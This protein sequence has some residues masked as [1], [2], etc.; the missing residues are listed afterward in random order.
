MTPGIRLATAAAAIF[1]IT[2]ASRAPADEYRFSYQLTDSPHV[3][4]GV[5]VGTLESDMNTFDIDALRD[6]DL[7]NVPVVDSFMVVSTDSDFANT[8]S[9]PR[10]TLD[11]SF[12]DFEVRNVAGTQKLLF[13]VGDASAKLYGIGLTGATSDFGSDG[14]FLG[15]DP[16]N[17]A[18]SLGAP[19]VA[20]APE[21]SCWGLMA[22]AIGVVGAALSLGKRRRRPNEMNA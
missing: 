1:W 3:V 11:A 5:L 8:N 20:A 7:D 17:F 14:R 12:L 16:E 10:A 21:P 15:F 2:A 19:A 13:G 6:V 18:A 4:N 9:S 22:L